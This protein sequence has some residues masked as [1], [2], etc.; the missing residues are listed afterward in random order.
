MKNMRMTLAVA[1]MFLAGT[2]FA[3]QDV[4]VTVPFDFYVGNSQL[5]P[6][7]TYRVS[8]CSANMIVV[9]NCDGSSA[10]MNMTLPATG[11]SRD[12]AKL[13]FRR[14]GDT[15]FLS[16]VEG[17]SLLGGVVLPIDKN[18]KKVKSEMATVHVTETIT[19][20]KAVETKPPN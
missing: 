16:Q 7:G 19:A 17:P 18:E 1:S 15:Y 11:P 12:R 9:R 10:V 20:P 14:Y 8:P 5:M 2:L 6:S 4:Q 3:Q 13:V